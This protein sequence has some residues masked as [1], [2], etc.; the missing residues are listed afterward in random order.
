MEEIVYKTSFFLWYII[1]RSLT[2]DEL[3]TGFYLICSELWSK[4]RSYNR[5]SEQNIYRWIAPIISLNIVIS[6][7]LINPDSVL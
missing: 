5:Y 3:T 6:M 7:V 4:H 1:K 2:S